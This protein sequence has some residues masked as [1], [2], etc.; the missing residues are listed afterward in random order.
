MKKHILISALAASSL[1]AANNAKIIEY[2]K[3]QVPPHIKV[4]ISETQKVYKMPKYEFINV[5]ISDGKR[6]QNVKMF[7][8]DDMLFPDIIDLKTNKSMRQELERAA[9]AKKLKEVYKK[10]D[11]ANIISLGNDPKKE[12]L[13]IFTDPECPYCRNELKGIEGRLTK[14]NLKLLITPVHGESALKKTYLAYK[15][16]KNLKSDEEKIKVLRKYYAPDVNL[17]GE[18]VSKDDI[19]SMDALRNRYVGSVIKGVPFIINEKEVK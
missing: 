12:T 10:E 14:N 1:F 16:T 17:T 19:K 9:M 7:A 11:S 8:K 5:K 6:S 3:A 15:N 18:K 2:F 4:E 13:V